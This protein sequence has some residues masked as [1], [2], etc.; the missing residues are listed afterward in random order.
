MV[1]IAGFRG[2]NRRHH[3]KP[4]LLGQDGRPPL[5]PC[6]EILRVSHQPILGHWVVENA[7]PA[8]QVMMHGNIYVRIL[9]TYDMYLCRLFQVAYSNKK[10]S[11]NDLEK[12]HGKCSGSQADHKNQHFVKKLVDA[13]S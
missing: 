13:K 12:N 6:S 10:N 3:Y 4:Q 7:N 11:H 9:P 2:A 1:M 5:P 8:D